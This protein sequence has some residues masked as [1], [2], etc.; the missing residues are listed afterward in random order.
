ME[1]RNAGEVKCWRQLTGGK[2]ACPSV[3]GLIRGVVIEEDAR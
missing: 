2:E 1:A 3:A